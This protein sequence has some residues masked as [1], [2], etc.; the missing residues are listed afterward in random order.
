MTS[1]RERKK[2]Q[3]RE[4]ILAASAVL[5]DRNGYENVSMREIAAATEVSYQTVYNYFSGKAHIL[6]Q[7]LL[8]EARSAEQQLVRLMDPSRAPWPGLTAAMDLMVDAALDI[9]KHHKPSYWR[10]VTAEMIREPET[11]GPLLG[12]M[13]AE[14]RG[15]F[16]QFLEVAR[17][18]GELA[19]TVDLQTLSQV[20]IYL[21]DHASLRILTLPG[22]DAAAVAE[23]VRA[24][25]R[26]VLAP[27]LVRSP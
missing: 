3:A 13:D 23:E 12:L 22:A 18:R 10:T 15:T 9:L 20:L 1:R 25:L 5:F 26:L 24:Q 7:I 2:A 4:R 21:V 6:Y 16:A 17:N 11:F 8:N 14:F 27:H 19:E